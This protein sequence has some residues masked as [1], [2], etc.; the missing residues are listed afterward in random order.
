MLAEVVI[1]QR[2]NTFVEACVN[3]FYL[4]QV[5][6]VEGTQLGNRMPSFF[7]NRSSVAFDSKDFARGYGQLSQSQSVQALLLNQLILAASVCLQKRVVSI[8]QFFR[9]AIESQVGQ[10]MRQP[11]ANVIDVTLGFLPGGG[12]H[13]NRPIA[14]SRPI[15]SG[16]QVY[17]RALWAKQDPHWRSAIH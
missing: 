5:V 6:A 8:E 12:N 7:C 3:F 2:V 15:E 10:R 1:A 16:S 9:A 11:L 4:A 17:D 13:S 14:E